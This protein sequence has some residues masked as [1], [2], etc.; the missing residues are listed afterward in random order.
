MKR[1]WLIVAWWACVAV[2]PAQVGLTERGDSVVLANGLLT[3]TLSKSTARVTSLRYRGVELARSGYYSMDGGE[4][5]RSPAGCRFFIQTNTPDLVDVGMRR[6]WRNEPQAVDVEIHYVLRRGDT[7]LYSYA[8]LDH[9]AAY[10]ATRIGEW[11]FVWK[12]PPD[13]FERICVDDRRHWLMQRARDRFE[14]TPIAE[15]IKLTSGIRAGQYDCKYDFNANYHDL[16]CWGHSSSTNQLGAW[17][18]LGSHEFFNDGPT[19]Q[20]LTAA[21][22]ILH[23]HF[24]LNHYNGSVTTLDAGQ[25][26]RKLYGPFLLY[27]NDGSW[28]DAQAR[29]RRDQQAWPH[30]WLRDNPAYP[31]AA[32]RGAVPARLLC[33]T[34][35]SRNSPARV[36]GLAWRSRRTGSSTRCITS[37]GTGPPPPATL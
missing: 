29:A 27:A 14:R 17:I 18:V 28:A 33:A 7:G 6:V 1:V 32:Q 34:R 37:T 26:W 25:A 20:D 22:D 13:L 10:P 23:L 30:A 8:V 12:L 3:A 11:R 35:S 36:P 19:K 31:L 16:G 4:N 21:A 9:P 5:Y 15:I 2:A 24:G